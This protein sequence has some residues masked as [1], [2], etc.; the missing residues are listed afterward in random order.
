MTVL[1]KLMTTYLKPYRRLVTWVLVLTFLQT[2]SS[3]YLPNLMSDIVDTG[4]IKGNI[5]YIVRIGGFMLA[6]TVL[7]GVGAV[8][9]NLYASKS[10]AG[11]GQILRTRVFG[12][13]TQFT[14][15]EFDQIGTSSLIVRTNNDIM[16]VQQLVNMMLRMMVI[17]PLTA[18]GGIIMAVYTDAS[19][20]WII[21]VVMPVLGLVIYLVLGNGIALFRA[22]QT[23]V[24]N[25]NR[26]VRENLS[27]VRVIRSFNRTEDEIDRFDGANQGL[28][29]VSVRVYKMMAALMPLMMVIINLSTIAIVWFGSLRVNSGQLQIGSL[30]AFIQYVMQI[31]FA[32]M[33]VSMMAFMIP[34]GQ[35]SAARINEVLAI[36]PQVTDPDNPLVPGQVR[37]LVEFQ[38]VTFSYPGAEEPAIADVSFTMRP[39]ETTA[40]IGGTGSGKTALVSLIPRFYDVDR[41]S[42]RVDGI[43]VRDMSQTALRAKIGFVPQRATLFTGSVTDNIR[44]GKEDASDA[45]VRHAA[46]VAQATDFVLELPQGFPSMISQGGSNLS[47]GQRQRL[48]IARAIVRNPEIYIFDDSFSAL[49]YRTERDLRHALK[50][51]L[52]GA[53]LLIVAQRVSTVME[54]DQIIVLEEGRIVGVG[55]HAALLE[56][57][58]VYKEIVASQ[59][60][61][62]ETA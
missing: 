28:T 43:D 14:L 58:H 36:R 53:S 18:I 62:E 9:A 17:A 8:C 2:L 5:G 4:I 20:S 54:A 37:G 13:V 27:G 19:L 48:S 16:Q 50:Q 51:E 30:M 29:D 35:A 56:S 42:V 23:K 24:D 22:M 38:H 57:S 61:E 7:G 12:H 15:Q 46:D 33:M 25:L 21:V 39:G 47:G 32:V 1:L 10:S 11:F 41:G 6:V 45:M 34:R 40:I 26:V 59:R 3:L 55:T 60:S 52:Q 31:M 49:D 44:Y